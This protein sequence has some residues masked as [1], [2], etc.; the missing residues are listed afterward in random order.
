M[1]KLKKTKRNKNKK[2]RDSDKNE[3]INDYNAAPLLNQF[4]KNE[5]SE[6]G[7][8]DENL[9]PAIDN[10]TRDFNK[11]INDFNKKREGIL[12]IQLNNEPKINIKKHNNTLK[13]MRKLYVKNLQLNVVHK[14]C[15]ILLEIKSNLLKMIS[16]HFMQRMKIIKDYIYPYIIL[17]TNSEKKI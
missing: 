13:F 16:H 2:S 5:K 12:E 9:A 4:N 14:D 1:K 7:E 8:E 17:K 15:F 3:Q 11:F 10:Q 6:E